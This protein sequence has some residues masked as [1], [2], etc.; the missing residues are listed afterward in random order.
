MAVKQEQRL[1]VCRICRDA[2]EDDD[3]GDWKTLHTWVSIASA[4]LYEAG[5]VTAFVWFMWPLLQKHF[6]SK[7]FDLYYRPGTS[8]MNGHVNE[9]LLTSFATSST[10]KTK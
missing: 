5:N 6:E 7:D 10:P 9:S 2:E 8:Y 3:G 1:S 4:S